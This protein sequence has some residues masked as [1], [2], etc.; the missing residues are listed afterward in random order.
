MIT[1]KSFCFNLF[2]E[3]TYVLFDETKQC[4]IVDPG[5]FEKAEEETL[6]QFI[7]SNGLSPVMLVNTHA[8]IDH[9]LG[10]NFVFK[11]YNLKP[12]LHRNEIRI[13]EAAPIIGAEWGIAVYPSPLPEKFLDEDDT[14]SF[15]N[16]SLQILFTPGHSPGSICLYSKEQSFIVSGDVLFLESI[17]RTDLPFGDHETLL[18][19]IR[20]KL[21]PLPDETIVYSGHGPE[22]SI[23]HEKKHNPFVGLFSGNVI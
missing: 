2:Y 21:F 11:T 4:I 3:N 17:G 7:S 23:G 16:S 12:V 6:Q 5:C 13:L 1:I 15:G 19:S 18:Q 9:V 14:V 22:T 10:N 20:Q 8:H